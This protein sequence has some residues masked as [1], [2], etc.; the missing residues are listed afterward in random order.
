MPDI[1]DAHTLASSEKMA[2]FQDIYTRIFRAALASKPA[3]VIIREADL[4][5]SFSLATLLSM[6]WVDTQGLPERQHGDGCHHACGGII[7]ATRQALPSDPGLGRVSGPGGL[8][9]GISHILLQPLQR[10]E[11]EQ[12]AEKALGC[13]AVRD[14]LVEVL[15]G[16]PPPLPTH[17]HTHAH[18]RHTDALATITSTHPPCLASELQPCS[19]GIR[20]VLKMMPAFPLRANSRRACTRGGTLSMDARPLHAGHRH[21]WLNRNT[22]RNC[23]I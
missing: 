19:C 9:V 12:L 1:H 18:Q 23:Y 10:A 20:F 6:A 15:I 22:Q 3:L 7:L 21:G 4:V 8:H 11:I 16:E 5:D 13:S 2:G 17:T 14:N